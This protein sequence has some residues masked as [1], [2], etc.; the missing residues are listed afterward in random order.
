MNH[1]LIHWT[2]FNSQ[3]DDRKEG[4]KGVQSREIV[5][6]YIREPEENRTGGNCHKIAKRIGNKKN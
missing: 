6:A 2:L 3:R 1:V 4:W 5:W